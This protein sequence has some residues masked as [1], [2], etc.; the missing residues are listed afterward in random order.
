[1]QTN[2]ALASF[3]PFQE[4]TLI[5]VWRLRVGGDVEGRAV[6]PAQGGEREWQRG[7]KGVAE[8][9]RQIAVAGVLAWST[10]VHVVFT[11]SSFS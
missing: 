6:S 4:R 11:A 3:F 2:Q 5:R 7:S 8:A 1:V 9:A 10:Y